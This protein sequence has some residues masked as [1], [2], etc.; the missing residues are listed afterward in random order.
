LRPRS[1][2]WMTSSWG[3]QERHAGPAPPARAGGLS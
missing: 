1:Q 2:R 3:T